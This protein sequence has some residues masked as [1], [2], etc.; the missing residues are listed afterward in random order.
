MSF[1]DGLYWEREYKASERKCPRQYAMEWDNLKYLMS[2]L[3]RHQD[4]VEQLDARVVELLDKEK[5]DE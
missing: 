3:K 2:E 4:L 5:G 1:A